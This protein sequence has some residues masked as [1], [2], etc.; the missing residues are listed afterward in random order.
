MNI[1]L[2]C[3][4]NLTQIN[5]KMLE[6]IL[7]DSRYKVSLCVVDNGNDSL[8]KRLYKNIKR[9]RGGYILIMSFNL[10]KSKIESSKIIYTE[11]FFRD[12]NVP[13]TY[14]ENLYSKKT[15]KDI[16]S[17]SSD[18]II[19]VSGFGIIKEPLL[20][21]NRYGVLSYHHGNMRKY[22]GQPPAFWEL[23]NGEKEMGVTV[24]RLTSGL[25]CG[26]PI[27]EKTV[28][29]EYTDNLSSLYKRV[30]E[31]TVDMMYEALKIVEK[32]SVF[33]ENVNELGKV[34]TMPN[35]RQWIIFKLKI[36]YRLLCFKIW[37]ICK[38]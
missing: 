4:K 16:E 9:G 11:H 24:Q 5:K 34:Y 18:A 28:P 36:V 35:L 27:I 14:T 31:E 29:I 19:L 33:L 8:T 1:V 38:N 13:I 26:A 7:K 2:L 37:N 6:P 15:I 21:L 3:S 22:R 17:T 25:D 20:S 32:K 23:Y 12:Y 10:L 30:S